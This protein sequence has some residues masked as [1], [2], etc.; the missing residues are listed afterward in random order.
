MR[1]NGYRISPS[2]FRVNGALVQGFLMIER[3]GRYEFKLFVSDYY[4]SL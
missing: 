4:L 3:S 1:K 2:I